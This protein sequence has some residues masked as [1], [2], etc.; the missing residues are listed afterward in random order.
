MTNIT[1][2]KTVKQK[3][4]GLQETVKALRV[5][6]E[7]QQIQA[8]EYLAGIKKLE[9]LIKQ[10]MD[11]Y[12]KPA[13]AIISATKEK[14]DPYLKELKTA[15]T[16]I[17]DELGRF[18]LEQKEKEEEKKKKLA[19]RVERGTMKAETAVRKMEEL[20][21]TQKSVKTETGK[22]SVRM[23]KEVVIIDESKLPREY[24]KPDLTKIRKDAL[25]GKEIDGVEVREKPSIAVTV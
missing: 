18:Y 11:K 19:E 14:Y 17:K 10:E 5:E 22:A 23:V 7:E 8:T 13:K 12:I 1:V 24:L 20:P 3:I 16:K 21:E 25:A 4:T 15:E 6:N 2:S 9:K